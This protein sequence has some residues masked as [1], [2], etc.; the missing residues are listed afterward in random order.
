M[1]NKTG[2]TL[3]ELMAVVVII[4]IVGGFV[5]QGCV[6]RGVPRSA[7]DAPM[8]E[9]EEEKRNRMLQRQAEA[10]ERQNELA[11]EALRLQQR[12]QPIER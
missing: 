10:M 6:M 7:H 9:T 11:E 8:F 4:V 12:K 2:F 3:V 5:Y 1:K